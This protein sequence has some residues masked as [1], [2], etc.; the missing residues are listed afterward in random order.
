MQ[1]RSLV[2]EMDITNLKA[3]DSYYK[4]GDGGL[5]EGNVYFA[6]SGKPDKGLTLN[7]EKVGTIGITI[8]PCQN[9]EEFTKQP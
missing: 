1:T 8:T 6:L 2:L 5:T 9:V 3:G 7:S 4:Y